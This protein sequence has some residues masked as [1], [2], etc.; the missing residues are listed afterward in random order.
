MSEGNKNEVFRFV[1][2]SVC[3]GRTQTSVVS[4]GKNV[5]V[6]SGGTSPAAPLAASGVGN[7]TADPGTGDG[8]VCIPT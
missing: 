3:V 7:D 6:W 4:A 2:V 1:L 5:A 8:V